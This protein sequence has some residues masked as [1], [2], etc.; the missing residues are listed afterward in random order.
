[1]KSKLT[2]CEKYSVQLET[3]SE[4]LQKKKVEIEEKSKTDLKSKV[5]QISEI[6]KKLQTEQK[7]KNPVAVKKEEKGT[8]IDLNMIFG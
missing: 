2:K 3:K 6:N 8:Q 5:D 4:S 1:M 7:K